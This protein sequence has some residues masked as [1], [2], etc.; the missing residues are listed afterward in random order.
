MRIRI[1]CRF[2]HEAESPTPSVVLAEPHT[3]CRRRVVDDHWHSEPEL[4]SSTY[5]DLYGNRCRRLELP[6]GVSTVEYD[7]VVEID[8][9]P[10]ATPGSGDEQHRVEDL[11]DQM[12]H[13]LLPSRYAESDTLKDRAWELFGKTEPG[14][15]RVLA[16]TEW[17]HQNIEYGVESLPTTSTLEIIE[18]RGGICRDMAHLGV[19]FCRALGIPTRYTCGYMPDIGVPD[20]EI[21]M[22]FHAWFE[23][24]LGERWWT[25][26]GRYNMPRIGRVPIGRGRDAADVA[27]ITTYGDATLT[28]MTVWAEQAAEVLPGAR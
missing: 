28:E 4:G 24:W 14:A 25:L 12:L 26:D 19:T 11:P 10:E 23:V 27:M 20:P 5:T 13:W 8:P 18:R 7:A 17:I 2:I 9:N 1:G 3:D 21:A 6:E 16:V 15:E 22:D